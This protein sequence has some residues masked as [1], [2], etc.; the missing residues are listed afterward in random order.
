MKDRKIEFATRKSASCDLIL[1][2]CLAKESTFIE[3]TEWANGEGFDISIDDR[4]FHLTYGELDAIN[5]LIKSL[6]INEIS[7]K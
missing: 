1:F 3:V 2:D 5:Y 7:K 4:M 6:E